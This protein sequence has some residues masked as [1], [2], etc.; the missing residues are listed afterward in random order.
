MQTMLSNPELTM[1]F[2]HDRLQT[3]LI[4]YGDSITLESLFNLVT[5]PSLEHI[6]FEKWS[7]DTSAWAQQALVSFLQRSRCSLKVLNLNFIPVKTAELIEILEVPTINVA[8]RE[9][10][11]QNEQSE[12]EKIIDADLCEL[13]TLPPRPSAGEAGLS[14]GMMN[15]GASR[16]AFCPNLEVLGLLACHSCSTPALVRMLRSR[17][18]RNFQFYRHPV[19]LPPAANVPQEPAYLKYF[20]TDVPLAIAQQHFK[21]LLYDGLVTLLYDS[22]MNILPATE[23]E[24]RLLRRFAAEGLQLWEYDPVQ[25]TWGPT[26]FWT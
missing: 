17:L 12:S 9:L 1:P 26:D 4:S 15:G 3:L 11:I 13:L 8:L 21:P 16:G 10:M 7:E 6:L 23:E 25:G 20:E 22:D 19:I 18:D 5:L 2:T 24:R 14:R